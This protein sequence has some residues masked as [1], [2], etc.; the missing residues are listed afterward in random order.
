MRILKILSTN[1]S[2]QKRDPVEEFH[3]R[4]GV[5]RENKIDGNTRNVDDKIG[6]QYEREQSDEKID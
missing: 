5:D 2:D 6:K 1:E 4:G 3:V